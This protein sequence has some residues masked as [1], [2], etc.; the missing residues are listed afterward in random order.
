M[1]IGN[2][3]LLVLLIL[4]ISMV[5]ISIFLVYTFILFISLIWVFVFESFSFGSPILSHGGFMPASWRSFLFYS[6]SV[7]LLL[8]SFFTGYALY[9]SIS[10]F[11]HNFLYFFLFIYSILKWVYFSYRFYSFKFFLFYCFLFLI[12]TLFY[13]SI[14]NFYVKCWVF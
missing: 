11:C 4:L 2:F 13:I 3:D 5:F 14:L 9:C 6:Q 12:A 7:F 10:I 1:R 8:L